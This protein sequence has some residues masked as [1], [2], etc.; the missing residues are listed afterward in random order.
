MV[1][2]RERRHDLLDD[3][4]T[5]AAPS[6]VSPQQPNRQWEPPGPAYHVGGGIRLGVD[7]PDRRSRRSSSTLS[8][9]SSRS[10]SRP[11][12]V[13]WNS[14]RREVNDTTVVRSAGA[15]HDLLAARRVVED[16]HCPATGQLLSP[17]LHPVV[18]L[19]R[20]RSA[21]TPSCRSRVNRAPA[22]SIRF[23]SPCRP[24]R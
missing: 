12:G 22:G 13:R 24:G 11:P 14:R 16:H 21:G 23:L 18:E 2:H 9:G 17:Q 6:A 15:G 7:R 8:C 4:A 1:E 3:A 5:R 20:T 19:H 10:A